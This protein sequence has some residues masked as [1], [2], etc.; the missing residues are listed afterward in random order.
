[1]HNHLLYYH[2][3]IY[4]HHQMELLMMNQN[5]THFQY[6]GMCL[7]LKVSILLFE[8]NNRYNK[9][10]ILL[11]NQHSLIVLGNMISLGLAWMLLSW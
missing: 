2:T 5:K 11:Y 7:L 1:M 9:I 3:T 4:R 8:N 6:Q 10:D